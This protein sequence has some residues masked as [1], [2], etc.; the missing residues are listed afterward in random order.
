GTIQYRGSD[1]AFHSWLRHRFEIASTNNSPISATGI[2]I[3]VSDGNTDI[4]EV[5]VNTPAVAPPSQLKVKISRNGNIVILEWPSGN[6]ESAPAITGPW[7]SVLNVNS[8]L[9]VTIGGTS[10]LFYRLRQ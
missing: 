3:K 10:Q 5:E 9:D 4:D 6:L 8:P 1:G 7:G 2:R